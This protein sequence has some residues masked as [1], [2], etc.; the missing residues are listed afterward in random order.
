VL[1]QIALP[2]QNFIRLA[3]L[4]YSPNVREKILAQAAVRH[5]NELKFVK[6]HRTYSKSQILDRQKPPP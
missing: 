6:F 3:A 4:R 1:R 2:E 5:P